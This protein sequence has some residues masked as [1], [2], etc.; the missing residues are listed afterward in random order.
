MI[1]NESLSLEAALKAILFA[2]GQPVELE[3]L[4]AFFEKNAEDIKEILQKIGT[5]LDSSDSGVM[6]SAT[7]N[8]TY[9]LCTRPEY[10]ETVANFMSQRRMQFLSNAAMEVLAAVAYNQPA[11]KTY[12]SQI[13]GVN[14]AE[15][16][17]NLVE[18]GLLEQAGRLDLPGRPMSYATTDKFLTVFSLGSLDDLPP[19]ESFLDPEPS[20]EDVA[21]NGEERPEAKISSDGGQDDIVSDN[22]PEEG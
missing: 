8:A 11:T 6:L 9:R 2:V 19:I 21:Q 5:E 7:A 15:I 14:S 12:I 17:D 20:L 1:L 18:K 4:A 3:K 22:V 13:R 16:V 10:G